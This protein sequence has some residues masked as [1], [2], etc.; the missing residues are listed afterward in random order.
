MKKKFFFLILFAFFTS[1]LNSYVPAEIMFK[2]TQIS[3]E[4]RIDGSLSKVLKINGTSQ[5]VEK[6][7]RNRKPVIVKIIHGEG[8][9][10]ITKVYQDL[11]EKFRK[12]INFISIN[13]KRNSQLI[14]SMM[15]KLGIQQAKLPIFMFF[16]NGQLLLPLFSGFNDKNKFSDII[17]K[18][19]LA[20]TPAISKK[21]L[22]GNADQKITNTSSPWEKIENLGGKIKR[23]MFGM[24]NISNEMK[25]YQLSK[26]W[27][28]T[29]LFHNGNV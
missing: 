2:H 21:N 4:K 18:K 10:S 19:F 17:S 12:E 29:P 23:W 3:H 8:S 13:M 26:R 14:S 22:Q 16:K 7:V 6:V 1:N 27:K 5:F 15:L 25:S 24:Q 9:E 20:K 28:N 11:A